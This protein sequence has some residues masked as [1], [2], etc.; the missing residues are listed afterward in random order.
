MLRRLFEGRSVVLRLCFPG[1]L[2]RCAFGAGAAP[3]WA[4]R[5]YGGGEGTVFS[6]HRFP[7]RGISPAVFSQLMGI[8]KEVP[9]KTTPIRAIRTRCLECAG[10]RKGVR[11]CHRGPGSEQPCA[12]Y[13]FRMGRNPSRAGIG[14]RPPRGNARPCEKRPSQVRVSADKKTAPQGN[15]PGFSL[16]H[17]RAFRVQVDGPPLSPIEIMSATLLRGLS[18]GVGT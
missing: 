1:L 6:V 2:S 14:G 12:V 16:G 18:G 10:S 5:Q 17:P 11:D 4:G 13:P 7:S 8:S 15:P 9:M 3:A